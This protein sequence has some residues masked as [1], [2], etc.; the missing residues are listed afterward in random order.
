MMSGN[1]ME[2]ST[3]LHD[4]NVLDFVIVEM[5]EYLDTHPNDTEAIEYV[6][7]YI[8]MKNKA[9]KDY[10]MRFGPLSISSAAD[11]NRKEWAWSLQPPPW[12][13]GC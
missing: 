9:M 6:N 4:I 8:H 1:N 7:H 3:L 12:E 11:S 5:T 2:Q 10:A 13:G